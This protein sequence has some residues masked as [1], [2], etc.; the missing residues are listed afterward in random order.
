MVVTPSPMDKGLAYIHGHVPC[1]HI[2][3]L[4]R[5]NRPTP[6]FPFRMGQE[7]ISGDKDSVFLDVRR[8]PSTSQECLGPVTGPEALLFRNA[9]H[10][11]SQLS[12]ADPGRL[13]MS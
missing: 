6:H 10:Y 9:L 4:S 1:F 12:P 5:G 2:L 11:M 3:V 7:R 8:S 13:K